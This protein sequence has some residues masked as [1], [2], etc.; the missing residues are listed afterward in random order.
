MNLFAAA[1]GQLFWLSLLLMLGFLGWSLLR[2]PWRQLAAQ[3]QR[4]HLFFAAILGLS[5]LWLL[6]VTVQGILAFHPLLIT[7]TCMVFGFS[8][9]LV[10]G[11]AALLLQVIYRL[12]LHLGQAHWLSYWQALDVQTLPVDFCI[13]IL[14][15]AAWT[16]AVLWFVN[17]L[18]FKNP[19]TYFLGVGFFGAMLGCLVMGASAWLLFFVTG[20]QGHQIAVEDNFFIFL[21]MA[22]PEGFI[23]G[24]MA[25]ALT[26]LAPELVRTYRDDWFVKD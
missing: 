18:H 16:Q 7:A 8:L 21:L 17:H 4:Q 9:T 20:N 5:L 10:V 26:V 2:A 13:S 14:V 11:A 19:F 23:N 22:F 12:A 24:S 3:Q 15:P 1:N 25:T 6:R